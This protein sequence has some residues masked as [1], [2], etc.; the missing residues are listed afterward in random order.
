MRTKVGAILAGAWFLTDM[1]TGLYNYI[2]NGNF[3]T[4]SDVIDDNLGT[5]EMYE[6]LY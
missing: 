5:Y 1:G 4:L 2:D 6:G 3:R